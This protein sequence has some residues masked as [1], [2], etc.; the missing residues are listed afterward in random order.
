MPTKEVKLTSKTWTL[1]SEAKA[2]MLEN[3]AGSVVLYRFDPALPAPID[4][5]GH[6][7]KLMDDMS[8]SRDASESLFGRTA[9]GEGTVVVTEVLSTAP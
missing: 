7:L 4:K 1:I 2:G 8:W 5:V 3:Q 9:T 6:Q